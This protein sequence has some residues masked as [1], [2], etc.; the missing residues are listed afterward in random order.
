MSESANEIGG[1]EWKLEWFQRM[2][3][4]KQLWEKIDVSS[5]GQGWKIENGAVT[6]TLRRFRRFQVASGSCI[7]FHEF[8][9]QHNVVLVVD[10]IF[11][12]N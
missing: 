1:V 8:K 7:W 11:F 3:E 6:R 2:N 10:G 4:L 5:S 9:A 12:F